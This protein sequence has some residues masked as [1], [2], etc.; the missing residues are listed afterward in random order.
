MKQDNP[1]IFIISAPSGTGKGTLVKQLL[2]EVPQLKRI[3]TATTRKKRK[4]EADG[5]SY[6]FL[7]EEEFLKRI[8]EDAFVEWNHIFDNYYGTL[9]ETVYEHIRHARSNHRDL[10]LEIDVDGKRNFSSHFKNTVS[11]FL[12]PPSIE[13][14]RNRIVNRD[15]ENMTEISKRLARVKEEIACKEGFNYQ[16]INDSRE[17]AF[18]QL[19][20][21]I[22]NERALRELKN[23]PID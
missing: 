23:K 22:E 7:S 16:V 19:K 12:L 6:I 11:I 3:I 8:E 9:K 20:L 1:L 10:I 18:R 17:E 14:L 5:K 13:E 21:I 15:S 2:E 4:G